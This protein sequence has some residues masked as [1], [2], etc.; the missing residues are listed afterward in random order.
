MDAHKYSLHPEKDVSQVSLNMDVSTHVSRLNTSIDI[1]TYDILFGMEEALV[2]ILQH[3][4][5]QDSFGCIVFGSELFL[6]IGSR[7]SPACTFYFLQSALSFCLSMCTKSTLTQISLYA[8]A[9]TNVRQKEDCWTRYNIRMCVCA[10]PFVHIYD[11]F[12]LYLTGS[13]K[14]YTSCYFVVGCYEYR[15]IQ[16]L[17]LRVKKIWYKILGVVDD[18]CY[19][20]EKS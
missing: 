18:A 1:E 4:A 9:L 19:K 2:V 15:K 20:H 17:F 13:Q 14:S 12:L 7:I 3:E 8:S 16:K 10:D 11:S 5:V 6:A